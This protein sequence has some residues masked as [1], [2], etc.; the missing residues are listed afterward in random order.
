MVVLLEII[1][2]CVLSGFSDE[3]IVRLEES[4]RLCVL[5]VCDLKLQKRGGL[6]PS[7]AVTP[8][9]IML[10]VNKYHLGRGISKT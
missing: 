4:Y 3:P 5:C 2:F 7:T 9:K 10:F 8:Q 6:G 1:M